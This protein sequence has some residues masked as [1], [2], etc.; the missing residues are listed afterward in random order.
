MV[1]M[2]SPWRSAQDSPSRQ[3]LWELSQLSVASNKDFY[4][5]LDR[6]NQERELIHRK[7]LAA[8]AA[9]HDRVREPAR[10]YN[11]K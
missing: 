6:E 4:A 3:L 5:R 11:Y 7:A 10:S 9:E 1:V 2:S 8:A